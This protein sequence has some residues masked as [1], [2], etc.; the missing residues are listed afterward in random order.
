MTTSPT[1]TTAQARAAWLAGDRAAWA[2]Y[3]AALRQLA[4][5]PPV[6]ADRPRLRRRPV[7]PGARA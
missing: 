2:R 7:R 3:T 1:E 4:E 6:R 5:A